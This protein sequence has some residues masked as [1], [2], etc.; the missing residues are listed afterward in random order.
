MS[1]TPSFIVAILYP[2]DRAARSSADPAAS[3]FGAL[4]T[5]L[6]SAGI[7]AEPA[8]YHDDFADEVEAQLNRV[9]LVLVWHNPIEGGR[10]RMTL[11]DML[12][13]AVRAK[14]GETI[15]LIAAEVGETAKALHQPM[16]H[17]KQAGRV[18]SA[19]QRHLTRYFPMHGQKTA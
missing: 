18:R 8:V 13:P 16:A 3:R 11:D 6:A 12:R 15:A 5:A 7:H 14:R 10:T 2:G 1:A 9:S 17:I 19:G 4:F